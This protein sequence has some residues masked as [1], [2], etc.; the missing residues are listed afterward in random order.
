MFLKNEYSSIQFEGENLSNGPDDT[1]TQNKQTLF[2]FSSLAMV[3]PF[4]ILAPF[5]STPI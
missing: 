1:T 4:Q 2:R 5:T 3:A